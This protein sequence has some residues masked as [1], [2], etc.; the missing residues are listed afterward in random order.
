MGSISRFLKCIV[1]AALIAPGATLAQAEAAALDDLFIALRDA[2]GPAVHAIEAKIVQEWSRSGSP[3][4]DLLLDRGRDAMEREDWSRAIEHLSA[5]VDH[6]PDFAEGWNARATAHF[7]AGRFG[8]ALRD[9]EQTLALNPRHFG[10]LSGLGVIMEQ[11]GHEQLALQA[12][13]A[14]AE[15]SPNRQ[16]LD[17]TLARLERKAMGQ[18]L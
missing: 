8:H 2:E 13:Q 17:E 9:I 5:L 4:I 16:E 1:A 15:L 14:V 18:T 3:S 12:W 11:L 7:Q 10:A 6:A